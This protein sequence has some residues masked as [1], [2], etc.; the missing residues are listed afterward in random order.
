M[1]QKLAV[2]A[3]AVVAVF[4]LTACGSGPSA[5]AR[6]AQGSGS[7]TSAFPVTVTQQ[8]GTVT[9]DN[10]PERVVAL[11]FP[12]ADAAIALGGV[13]V[14]MYEVSYVD[15]GVQQWTKQALQGRQP[16]LINTDQGFPFEQ[17]ARLDPDVILATNTY[18]LI[19][20][21]WDK[22]N[23]IA[24]VVGHVEA[25]GV[26]SWQ[27]GVGQIG[28]AL[29]REAE[30]RRLVA[31]VEAATERA[32][33]GHPEFAGKTVSFFNYVAGDGLYVVF[34]RVPAVA[35]SAFVPLEQLVPRLA[36]AASR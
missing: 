16:E 24:P 7:G 35:R 34:S 20:D 19:A 27:Q 2:L 15:G 26:D 9:I 22:L 36:R 5:P 4:S 25:P 32:R 33:A 28:K 13:P 6:P 17:I 8:L 11:D 14:G 10:R 29:G 12:S 31:Q 3:V 30:A 23:A 1:R 21:N 18:P